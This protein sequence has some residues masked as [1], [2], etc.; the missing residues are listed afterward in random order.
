[1]R[2]LVMM[3]AASVS[4]VG[5]SV[6]GMAVKDTFVFFAILRRG[7]RQPERKH[8]RYIPV[9]IG[10]ARE[11]ALDPRLRNVNPRHERGGDGMDPFETTGRA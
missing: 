10:E 3:L 2:D 5:S 1:M 7:K 6:V 8:A 4:V 9:K 11:R